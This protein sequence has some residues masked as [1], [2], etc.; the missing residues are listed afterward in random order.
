MLEGWFER[1]L[2]IHSPA[3]LYKIGYKE[4]QIGGHQYNHHEE[5]LK[6]I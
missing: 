5:K 4:Y 1:G 6:S 3:G 2:E